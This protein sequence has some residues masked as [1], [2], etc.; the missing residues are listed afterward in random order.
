MERRPPE[1]HAVHAD[2]GG[3]LQNSRAQNSQS[4]SQMASQGGS[5]RN[6][7]P[8]L[9]GRPP[10]K[11]V[12]MAVM[13]ARRPKIT[14][15]L[16]TTARDP[17]S[18][19]GAASRLTTQQTQAEV[20]SSRSRRRATPTSQPAARLLCKTRCNGG[21]VALPTATTALTRRRPKTTS[22]RRTTC[23]DRRPGRRAGA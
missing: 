6:K 13:G 4:P 11:G 9:S 7:R 18:A 2:M 23:S 15:W 12:A 10:C 16:S 3:R 19:R 20:R 17:G 22:R 1:V 8:G 21:C 14:S 5:L